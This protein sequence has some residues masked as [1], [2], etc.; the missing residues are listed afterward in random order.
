MKHFTHFRDLGPDV[1]KQILARASAMKAGE[2]APVLKNKLLGLL[3]LDQLA[4]TH[5]V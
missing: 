2:I 4:H 1:A 3:F 5:L